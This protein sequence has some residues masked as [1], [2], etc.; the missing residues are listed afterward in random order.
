[1]AGDVVPKALAIEGNAGRRAHGGDRARA[2][3]KCRFNARGFVT[4]SAKRARSNGAAGWQSGNQHFQG[5]P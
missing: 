3:R 5:N 1:M 4:W 2:E